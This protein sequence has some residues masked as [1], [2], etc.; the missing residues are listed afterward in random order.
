VI[1]EVVQRDRLRVL[2]P[3]ICLLLISLWLAFRRVSEVL[4]SLATL[5]FSGLCLLTIMRCAGWSWNLLNL[6]ALPLLLG[7]GVDYSIHMQLALRRHCGDVTATRR[8]IGRALFLCA[9]TTVVGF[10]SLAWSSNA[11]LA[12]LGKICAA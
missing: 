11:G 7:S 8:V 9:A 3:M 1:L 6:T 12:S 2:V 10:G 5:A 4:L